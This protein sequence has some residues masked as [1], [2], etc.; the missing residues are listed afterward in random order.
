[1]R[2]EI[3]YLEAEMEGVDLVMGGGISRRTDRVY[4]MNQF[5]LMFISVI[6]QENKLA[7]YSVK[8][9]M[10]SPRRR[11]NLRLPYHLE[12]NDVS[13]ESYLLVKILN[14]QSSVF[15]LHFHIDSS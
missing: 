8:A 7:A 4:I 5:E 3:F 12:A 1:M 15:E 13:V 10:I 6:A 9:G 14:H 11:R 2:L